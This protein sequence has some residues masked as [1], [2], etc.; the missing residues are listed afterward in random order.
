MLG[1]CWGY[2]VIVVMRF[3]FAS[4]FGMWL[5]LFLCVVRGWLVFLLFYLVGGDL[6]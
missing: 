5:V 3:N 2:L 6:F 1:V 4:C